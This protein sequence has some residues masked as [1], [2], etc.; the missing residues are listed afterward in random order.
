M[1]LRNN[2]KGHQR[3]WGFRF[4]PV[5]AIVL[6]ITAVGT[7]WLVSELGTMG[8]IPAFV[9]L[10]FFLFCNVF[11]IR[12]APELIWGLCFVMLAGLLTVVGRFYP[13]MLMMCQLPVTVILIAREIRHPVYHGVFA[14]RLNPNDDRS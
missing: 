2:S 3:T 14:R 10:H 11:R 1:P 5:D 6:I 13:A 9:V 7:P 4:S 12:R 8:L